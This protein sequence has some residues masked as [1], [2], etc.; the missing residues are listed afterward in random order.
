MIAIGTILGVL[1]LFTAITVIYCS[2]KPRN[3]RRY[4]EGGGGSY[5]NGIIFPS[6]SDG[7]PII[8]GHQIVSAPPSL[9]LPDD[10]RHL[11]G[12]TGGGRGRHGGRHPNEQRSWRN[13]DIDGTPCCRRWENNHKNGKRRRRQIA[14]T[15][16]GTTGDS[17]DDAIGCCELLFGHCCGTKERRNEG[18][19]HRRVYLD[20]GLPQGGGFPLSAGGGYSSDDGGYP[21]VVF[22]DGRAGGG[23]LPCGGAGGGDSSDG[24]DGGGYLGGRRDGGG[25]GGGGYPGSGGGGC[26]NGFSNWQG[27]ISTLHPSE[28]QPQSYELQPPYPPPLYCPHH[29]QHRRRRSRS[30]SRRRTHP[31]T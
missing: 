30:R 31:N 11:A 27:P 25:G 5:P 24:G 16:E 4:S 17:N 2:K 3:G 21:G 15:T 23:I 14:G 28:Q 18:R 13:R 7:Y 12:G 8:V 22:P 1:G 26:R 6:G 29:H 10:G 19:R 9:V 20:H